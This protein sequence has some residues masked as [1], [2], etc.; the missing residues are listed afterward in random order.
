MGLIDIPKMHGTI[1]RVAI[2]PAPE[3]GLDLAR[4]GDQPMLWEA[5]ALLQR[6]AQ[7]LE[8][9]NIEALARQVLNDR[10]IQH[11]GGRQWPCLRHRWEANGVTRRRAATNRQY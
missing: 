6:T 3:Q 10:I 4:N 11:R 8:R 5:Q 1:P 9:H 7:G 2:S